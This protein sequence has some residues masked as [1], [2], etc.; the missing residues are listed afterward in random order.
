MVVVAI[1]AGSGEVLVNRLEENPDL[2]ANLIH[3]AGAELAD[4]RLDLR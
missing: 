4:Y 2:I 1:S 3:M